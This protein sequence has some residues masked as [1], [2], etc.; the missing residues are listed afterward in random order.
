MSDEQDLA[1]ATR[2][3]LQLLV[4]NFPSEAIAAVRQASAE[5]AAL[6]RMNDPAAEPWP[7]MVVAR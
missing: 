6:R 4:A 2:M 5:R 3:G 1:E 7:P